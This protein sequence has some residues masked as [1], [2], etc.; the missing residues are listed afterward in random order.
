MYVACSTQC[1]GSRT[2]ED[3]LGI[4]SALHFN[5]FDAA[6]H[7]GGKQLRPSEV[8]ADVHHAAARLR[9]GPGLMPCAFSVEIDAPTAAAPHRP[10]LKPRKMPTPPKLGVGASCHRSAEGTATRRFRSEECSSTQITP[11]ATGKAMIATAVLTGPN[12]SRLR[13]ARCLDSFLRVG[14]H[15]AALL[16]N[17]PSSW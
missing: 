2:L 15:V 13:L 9:Y 6:I 16:G 4:I 8:A 3:A 11:A 12:G 14:H 10:A 5:K 17:G 7:E 1:F